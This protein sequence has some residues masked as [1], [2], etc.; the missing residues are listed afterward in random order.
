MKSQHKFTKKQIVTS[1]LAALPPL[2]IMGLGVI[3]LIANTIINTCFVIAYAILPLLSIT[4]ST[5][6][7][8]FAWKKRYAMIL[9]IILIALIWYIDAQFV[10]FGYYEM[11]H[12]YQGE[13]VSLQYPE[14]LDYPELMPSLDAI[15]TPIGLEYHDYFAQGSIIFQCNS[16]ILIATYDYDDYMLQKASLDGIFKFQITPLSNSD[17][18]SSS[19]LHDGFHFRFLSLADYPDLSYPKALMLIGTNDTTHEIAYI[20]FYDIDLDI[21]SSLEWFL[22][23]DCGWEHIR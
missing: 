1:V 8:L 18:V 9:C 5:L 19:W 13:E 7:I 6:F 22:D 4:V 23:E 14:N 12:T 3:L 16:D 10:L 21:I 2:V 15:G 11:L 17:S 20:S